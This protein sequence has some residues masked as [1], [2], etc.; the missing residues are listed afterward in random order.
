MLK[1]LPKPKKNL[2]S[3]IL[4]EEA[5]IMDKAISKIA[6]SA[7]FISLGFLLNTDDAHAKGGGHSSHSNYYEHANHVY[8]EGKDQDLG[9]DG[10]TTIQRNY[11]EGL[12][13]EVQPKEVAS[14]HANHYNHT[15]GSSSSGGG[16]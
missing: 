2:K 9:N 6:I 15:N 4:G 1:E 10:N 16:K 3:F 13:I 7:S 8:H 12:K 5:K 14:G 11:P